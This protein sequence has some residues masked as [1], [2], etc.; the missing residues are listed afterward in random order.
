MIIVTHCVT[1]Y[2]GP[3]VN[4]LVVIVTHCVTEC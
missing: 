1:E 3:L 2:R 4:D